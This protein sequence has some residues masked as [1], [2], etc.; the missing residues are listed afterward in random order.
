MKLSELKK[1]IHS[2]IKEAEEEQP[3]VKDNNDAA[4]KLN[5]AFK[6]Q[7]VSSFVDQ[8]KTIASDPKVQ[9]ILKAG[10]TDG[11]PKDEQIQYAKGNIAVKGLLPTQNEIGFD[12]SIANILTDQYG[13]LKSILG[14]NADVGGPIV[15]Y[16]GKYVIDGHHR[17]SQVYAANPNASMENLDIRGNLSPTEILKI[18]HAA[19]AAKVGGVPSSNPQGINIL[20]G[21]TEKQV[22][23]AVNSKLSDTATKNIWA[24]NGQKDNN[25]IAKYIYNNLK[26]LITK[27]KPVAGAPGRKDMPQTDNKGAATD[28]LALLQKGIV[29]FD[30]PQPTDVKEHIKEA[31]RLQKLAGIITESKSIKEVAPAA[32]APAPKQTADVASLTK[33]IQSNT[34]LMNKLKTVNSGQ[35][36]TETIAFILNNINPKATGVNKSKLKSIIDQRFQ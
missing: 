3:S 24:E 20:K 14:G 29:N 7:D 12:Q 10:V 30:N 35:E 26:T 4:T 25:A 18:V 34:S 6:T 11:D 28:K 33:M 27:N 16:N 19:I 15:T 36:V 22:L 31:K 2:V 21:V 1:I 23:D 9:A 17:W 5:T 13:S 32:P 8:F